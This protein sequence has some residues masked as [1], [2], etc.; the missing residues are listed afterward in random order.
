MNRKRE[1]ARLAEIPDLSTLVLYDRKVELPPASA[2]HSVIDLRL[3]N[4]SIDLDKAFTT[5]AKHQP[6]R[7]LEVTSWKG[8][9]FE[10]PDAIAKLQ[11]IRRLTLSALKRL[12]LSTAIGKLTKLEALKIGR[13]KK[14]PEELFDCAALV[15][16]ELDVLAYASIPSSIAQL[17]KLRK[18]TLPWHGN[19][20]VPDELFAMKLDTFDGPTEIAKRIGRGA[21]A[22]D[23]DEDLAEL[24]TY[25]LEFGDIGAELAKLARAPKLAELRLACEDATEVPAQIGKL[26][27]LQGLV[28]S[29]DNTTEISPKLGDL[30]QLTS[31]RL[32]S[33]KLKK[34]PSTIGNLASLEVLDVR[35]HPSLVIPDAVGKLPKLDCLLTNTELPK[36]LAKCPALEKIYWMIEKAPPKSSL[37]TLGK[38]GALRELQIEHASSIDI[39]AIGR[40]FAN[41]PLERLD[42]AWCATKGNDLSKLTSLREICLRE[43]AADALKLCEGKWSRTKERKGIARFR[44]RAPK[45]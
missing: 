8:G 31:L 5:L 20:D 41:H 2:M 39:D 19:Y 21:Q 37:E 16:L 3:I 30:A 9:T 32:W 25:D 28:I 45:R 15:E 43:G 17:A 35:S 40:A 4:T 13:L 18:L 23:T 12:T 38:L 27:R 11:Q 33:A 10:V 24:E 42:L 44:R 36:G 29:Q 1:L 34:L 22:T 7:A 14:I 26:T 6:L